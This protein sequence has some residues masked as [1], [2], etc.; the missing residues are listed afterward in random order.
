MGM[1]RAVLGKTVL[2]V[3]VSLCV[4]SL[5]CDSSENTP[6]DGTQ[7]LPDPEATPPLPPTDGF[8]ILI[9]DGD[10]S[11]VGVD[12]VSVVAKKNI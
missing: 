12:V 5:G 11:V 4:P 6:E 1:L 3:C 9:S 10:A 7:T 2:A 8:L